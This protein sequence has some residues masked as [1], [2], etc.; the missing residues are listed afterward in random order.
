MRVLHPRLAR[1]E[2]G[3]SVSTLQ[4]IEEPLFARLKLEL[5]I[6]RDDL[7]HPVVSGNKWRKLKYSLN[8]ALHQDAR[9]IVSMGGAYSNFLHALAFACRE[10]GLCSQ[11]FVRGEMPARL[12]PTLLDL[13][14]FGMALH[15]TPRDAYRELRLFNTAGGLPMLSAGD[16]WLPEGGSCLQALRGVGEIVRE[17]AF[18][19]D[20]FCCACGTGAT[21]AGLIGETPPPQKVLGV[22]VL[23]NAGY[24]RGQVADW[25]RELGLKRDNWELL[26]DYHGG[27][28]GKART[29]LLDFMHEFQRR[30]GVRLEP[31]YTGKLLFAVFDL[32]RR[33]YF[34][35][36]SR[37]V[38]L[39][40]GGLQGWR[41]E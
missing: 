14:G 15:F 11:G 40:S 38:V 25:L 10:L 23:K 12:S 37:I 29:E 8:D 7:L 17:I 6:K 21:L 4:R 34:P 41:E 27:G 33:G 3:F 35:A 1:F 39:H 28:F 32:A 18:G 36:G 31:V 30:H 2:R 13:R 22:A 5:W 9:C 16:Y 26:L 24:L 19:Y 20:F